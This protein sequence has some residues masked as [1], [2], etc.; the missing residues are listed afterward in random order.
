MK[1][2]QTDMPVY[3]WHGQENRISFLPTLGYVFRCVIAFLCA[4]GCVLI[5]FDS[6]SA[7]LPDG[8]ILISCLVFSAVF[9]VAVY[10]KKTAAFGAVA[11]AVGIGIFFTVM[12]GFFNV[13]YAMAGS[14]AN[15]WR[16]QLSAIGY[17]VEPI[18]DK[19]ETVLCEL[20]RTEGEMFVFG[21]VFVSLAVCLAVAV[22][23]VRRVH[24]MPLLLATLIP[25]AY[26]LLYGEAKASLGA[27]FLIVSLSAITV[28]F[29]HE[30]TFSSK[31]IISQA[32]LPKSTSFE[33]KRE[34][35]HTLR[36]T[37]ALGGFY[38]AVSVMILL[39]VIAVPL[40]MDRPMADIPAVSGAISRTSDV[41]ATVFDGDL[42]DARGLLYVGNSA[43]KSRNTEAHHRE[44]NS[45]PV[46]SVS[47]NVNAP[48]YLRSWTG[49]DYI[50]DS[51]NS[52]SYS[53]MNKYTELFG[54]GF[55]AELL[56]NELL[57]AVD[58]DLVTL[59]VTS[60]YVLHEDFG[61]AV[62]PVHVKPLGN[63][64]RELFLPSYTDPMTNLLY[65]GTRNRHLASFKNYY[66]GIFTGKGLGLGDDYSVKAHIALPPTS[67]MLTNVSLL[68]RYYNEEREIV[69]AMRRLLSEGADAETI[70]NEYLLRTAEHENRADTKTLSGHYTF[71][72]GEESLAYRYTYIMTDEER[73]RVDALIDSM[74]YYNNYVY[75]NYITVCE[76][77]EAF[78]A[79]ADKIIAESGTPVV[80]TYPGRHRMV[81]A[82]I[83][84]LSK[85]M[86]YTLTPKSPTE[87]REYYN[88]AETF[89]FDTGEGYCVQYATSAAMLL[90]C[91]GIPARYAVGYIANS[92]ENSDTGA[93]GT[94]T[95]VVTENEAH[96]WIEVY[97][98]YYGWVQYE[99]TAPFITEVEIMD[100]PN[101]V[102]ETVGKPATNEQENVDDK[103]ETTPDTS[104]SV[105][106]V[107]GDASD[108]GI[109]AGTVILI[110]SAV[111]IA[112]AVLTAAIIAVLK[113]RLFEARFAALGKEIRRDG[114]SA[115]ERLEAARYTE[116]VIMKLLGFCGLTPKDAEPPTVFFARANGLLSN[117]IGVSLISV[118]NAVQA[119]EFGGVITARELLLLYD[120]AERLYVHTLKKNGRIKR[121]YV[122]FFLAVT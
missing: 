73:V 69:S 11:A 71:P 30:K 100:A 75:G 58:P 49:V 115:E 93:A 102:Q 94:F 23:S 38:G 55:S 36:T 25:S 90:R 54:N 21:A 24:L 79:L 97:Y 77:Y 16:T 46:F 86:T 65:Y 14:L 59:P 68:V 43:L 2:N 60:D 39:L 62:S 82:V 72:S 26:F 1:R 12:G 51:W 37:S 113:V 13:I 42:P 81:E 110:I 107:D 32:V 95:A 40:A 70:D 4:Y 114:L 109:S 22:L 57:G 29:F 80:Y 88:S 103:P 53:R 78:D 108:R 120:C 33:S 67:E 96:A 99:A 56:T 84:Y 10:S 8:V 122:K 3:M 31:R 7:P 5:I 117:E 66:E 27:A 85:N 6:I 89:L 118:G 76:N 41:V 44:I 106:S 28:M 83:D 48:I 111:V 104:P 121:C 19:L 92:F 47:A 98:D 50:G 45:T 87:G 91:L 61:Y 18:G 74:D 20:E 35:K 52:V 17:L 15:A 64:K 9:S 101:N 34:L 119:C 63:V 112:T 116:D 105:I